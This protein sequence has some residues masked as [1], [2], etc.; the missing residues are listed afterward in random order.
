MRPQAPCL[1]RCGSETCMT[2]LRCIAAAALTAA[3]SAC[4]VTPPVARNEATTAS[5]A[6]SS[7]KAVAQQVSVTGHGGRLPQPEREGLLKRLANESSLLKRH[8]AAMSAF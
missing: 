4:A 5:A 8:V 3:L 1:Q 7:V 6:A 2:G